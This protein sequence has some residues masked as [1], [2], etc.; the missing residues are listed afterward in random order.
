ME[1]HACLGNFWSI[2]LNVINT[3]KAIVETF[4]FYLLTTE[5]CI[6]LTCWANPFISFVSLKWQKPPG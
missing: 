5:R 1:L 3:I 6:I 4:D 2:P